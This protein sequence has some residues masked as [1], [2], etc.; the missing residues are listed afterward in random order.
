MAFQ[1]RWSSLHRGFP[2]ALILLG[3]LTAG[4]ARSPWARAEPQ[5]SE[6]PA[7]LVEMKSD[8]RFHPDFV[9]IKPGDVVE[10]R[11]L[12]QEVL[13][14][15][16]DPIRVQEPDQV[17]VPPSAQPFSTGTL[18]PQKSYRQTFTE[19]GQYQFSCLQHEQ[20]GM[21]GRAVVRGPRPR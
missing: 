3:F 15:T 18:W 12:T 7:I 2:L 5:D 9:E 21:L 14:V 20:D 13:E 11:N 1:E 10:F 17:E 19:P 4:G 16:N 8:H 6:K